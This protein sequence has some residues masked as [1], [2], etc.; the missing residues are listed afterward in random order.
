MSVMACAQKI[1]KC[2]H[3]HIYKN[4]N[5]LKV[6]D[7][8][9]QKTSFTEL[10]FTIFHT[11]LSCNRNRLKNFEKKKKIEQLSNIKNTI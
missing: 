8:L 7:T 3:F 9:L 10:I 6:I 2:N 5:T 1:I 4:I 11:L